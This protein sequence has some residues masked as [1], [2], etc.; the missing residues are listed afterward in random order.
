MTETEQF[1]FEGDILKSLLIACVTEHEN[2][3]TI[4]EQN[5]IIDKYTKL[6]TDFKIKMK[7]VL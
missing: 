7:D 3:N 5:E 2:C 4:K 1:E 6:M